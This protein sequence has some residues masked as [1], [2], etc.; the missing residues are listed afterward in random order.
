MKKT[1]LPIQEIAVDA[2]T[3]RFQIN[4]ALLPDEPISFVLIKRKEPFEL[5]LSSDLSVQN[6]TTWIQIDFS[7]AAIHMKGRFDFYLKTA[8]TLYKLTSIANSLAK[9]NERYFTPFQCSTSLYALP[10]LTI[11]GTFS[12]LVED[13]QKVFSDPYHDTVFLHKIKKRG[14]ELFLMFENQSKLSISHVTIK[15]R[16][17]ET[18]YIL[19]IKKHGDTY[20]SV[21]FIPAKVDWDPTYWDFYASFK[22]ME[23]EI[24]IRIKNMRIRNKIKLQYFSSNYNIELSNGFHIIPYITL[25]EQLSLAF[26]KK[27]KYETTWYKYKEVAAYLVYIFFGWLFNFSKIWLIHEK[28]SET[29]QDNA[30][31]FFKFLYKNH[32][33]KKAYFVIKSDSPDFYAT[34]PYK[35]RTV[36]FMSFKH[37]LLVLVSKRIISSESKGHGY[38]WRLAQGLIRPV[39]DRKPY[40]FLQHGVLGL[41][42]IDTIFRANG[43]NHADLFITSSEFEKEI[44]KKYLGYADKNIVVTGLARWDEIKD[45]P[46]TTDKKE[47]LIMPTWRN[48]LEEAEETAFLQSDYFTHYQQLIQSK[49]LQALLTEKEVTLNFYLHPK[50][51][52]YSS[53][54]QNESN[55]FI[56]V[57]SFGEEKVNQL[58]TNS[59]ALITDY[60]SVAWEY[61]YSNKPTIF[62]QFDLNR[63]L[64]EQ[65]SYMN[66]RK[67]LFG[68]VAYDY[69]QLI[70]HIRSLIKND[71]QLPYSLEPMRERYFAYR[72][73]AHSERIFNAIIAY[74]KKEAWKKN[75]LQSLRRNPILRT[76]YYKLS[77]KK[78]TK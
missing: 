22:L 11:N 31:A 60:S 40:V 46:T 42:Q 13:P 62:F 19:P 75:M 54:F 37:L 78:H 64:E 25:N 4:T 53:L 36:A 65:G 67:D 26:R 9:T 6:R 18:A 47:I 12:F 56:R 66:L 17:Q 73:G 35:K 30:F 32:P 21:S 45:R 28:F 58:I 50:F 63:Y 49:E 72:E 41:K 23:N 20:F 29:A 38:V 5:S 2:N 34:L 44:V 15:F 14:N 33:E 48:W 52:H 7:N 55:A 69:S 27:S 76:L 77:Q 1:T 51:I 8:K 61:L 71:F 74:E 57:F 3:I 10:Y 68:P 59:Q 16:K 70:T 24:F 43:I 39:L